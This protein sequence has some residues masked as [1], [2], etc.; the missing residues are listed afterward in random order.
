MKHIKSII[1]IIALS[2]LAVSC[3]DEAFTVKGNFSDGG[4]QNI[5]ALYV[6]DYETLQS[7]WIT[8]TNGQFELTGINYDWTIVYLINNKKEI[9]ARAALKNGDDIEINGSMAD[10][11]H[12]TVT[13]NDANEEWNQFMTENAA[14]YASADRTQ[15]NQAIEKYVQTNPNRISST[16]LLLNDYANIETTTNVDTLFKHISIDARPSGLVNNYFALTQQLDTEKSNKNIPTI[17]L[18]NSEDTIITISTA[19][20]KTTLLYFWDKKDN[21]KREVLK[22]LKKLYAKYEEEG[23]L[24]VADIMMSPD[25]AQWH[26]IL[27]NDSTKWKH[28]WA[29]GGPLNRSL[30]NINV[31]N[32]PFYVV[33]T[34]IGKQLYRGSSIADAVAAT[35]KNMQIK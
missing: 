17:M 13:G 20:Y 14:L 21:S 31:G 11:Y 15:L 35:E 26:K 12:V 23:R 30:V 18:F 1:A 34:S 10:P 9:I 27:T 32:T 28:Y 25:S 29:P 33:T 4:T 2:L 7:E 22:E 19:R 6:T 3:K 8:M 5:R 16:L 24:Q